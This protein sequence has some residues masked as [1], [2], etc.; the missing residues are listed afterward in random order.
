MQVRVC[1]CIRDV[2]AEKC[3]RMSTID[4]NA[5]IFVGGP[6]QSILRKAAGH[7]VCLLPVPGKSSLLHSWIDALRGNTGVR[8]ISV[9]TGRAEDVQ[10]LKDH[11]DSLEA[12]RD[13]EVTIHADK[14][15]HRGTAGALKDFIGRQSG[16]DEILFI[17]GN[18]VPP[19]YPKSLFCDDFMSEDVA[20]VLGKS[21]Q[22]ETAG[23]ILMKR[24]ILDLVPELGFFDFKEQLIPRVLESGMRILV[25]EI[26][27]RSV[28]FSTPSTYLKQLTDYMLSKTC[29]ATGPFVSDS[30]NVDPST[31]L[32]ANVIVGENVTIKGGCLVQ[33]S[34]ILDGC[35]IGADSTLVRS[36]V[37]RNSV[38]ED[39]TSSVIDPYDLDAPGSQLNKGG[40]V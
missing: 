28:R 29:D 23:V 20:A 26:T 2:A 11:V 30:A 18:R 4:H 6:G 39:G 7:P 21:S 8:S 31:V 40:L 17:E 37:T 14:A 22:S 15:L 12:A 35:E 16:F 24:E 27:H 19:E 3:F 1:D 10:L 5:I 34:V 38:I 32:G 9:V 33:D 13:F 36:I 25:K